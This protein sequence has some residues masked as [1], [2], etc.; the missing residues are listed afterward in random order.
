[1]SRSLFYGLNNKAKRMCVFK[2]FFMYFLGDLL[3]F[4]YIRLKFRSMQGRTGTQNRHGQFSTLRPY[5]TSTL[6]AQPWQK[7]KKSPVFNPKI[8]LLSLQPHMDGEKTNES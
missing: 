8:T 4:L 5:L 7:F 2:T 1:M 3:S 6:L